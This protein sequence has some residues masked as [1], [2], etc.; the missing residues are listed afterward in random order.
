[1]ADRLSFILLPALTNSVVQVPDPVAISPFRKASL[2]VPSS[3]S[4]L[5]RGPSS[6]FGASQPAA[7][8]AGTDPSSSPQIKRARIETTV[9]SPASQQAKFLRFEDGP[10]EINSSQQHAQPVES[11]R[12]AR[13]DESSDGEDSFSLAADRRRLAD[14][15]V[16]VQTPDS[17]K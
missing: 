10:S 8:P 16:H 4:P 7:S 5:A 9:S 15:A 3:D 1:M 11:P 14:G 6:N 13:V 12:S 17:A 2:E